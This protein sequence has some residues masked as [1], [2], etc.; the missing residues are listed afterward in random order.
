MME[1]ESGDYNRNRSHSRTL[2]RVLQRS[3]PSDRGYPRG[4][5]R[6]RLL[7]RV[8]RPAALGPVGAVGMVL[9]HW[10]AYSLAAPRASVRTRLLASTGH[11]YWFLAVRVALVC[12][13]A[14]VA[15][16]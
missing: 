14:S 8:G 2:D 10:I 3:K 16:V 15:A 4:G 13:L 12:A 11:A 9:G 7:R 5:M 6:A 1:G